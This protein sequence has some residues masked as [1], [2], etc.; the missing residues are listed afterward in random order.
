MSEHVPQG[1]DLPELHRCYVCKREMTLDRFLTITVRDKRC[2]PGYSWT[3]PSW[4]CRECRAKQRREYRRRKAEESGRAFTPRGDRK[5]YASRMQDIRAQRKSERQAA[6]AV[7]LAFRK[8]VAMSYQERIARSV[9]RQR[10]RYRTDPEYQAKVKAKKIRRKRAQKG[11]QVEPVSIHRVA[12]RDGWTCA[13]CG[14][15]V[16][17]ATWSLD[18]VQPL[19]KGGAHTYANVVLAHRSCNSRR[20]AGR[21]PVRAPALPMVP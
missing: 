1:S 18:H 10:E 14:L 3:G 16:T 6:W 5:E 7:C 9:V 4:D 8:L 13:I 20:G 2:K 21:F 17:R 19:S 15:A 11:T 12:E